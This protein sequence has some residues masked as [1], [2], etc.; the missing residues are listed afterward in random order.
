MVRSAGNDAVS[1][2]ESYPSQGERVKTLQNEVRIYICHVHTRSIHL[3][4]EHVGVRVPIA[5]YAIVI[6]RSLSRLIIIARLHFMA[7]IWSQI[8]QSADED[9]Y[10]WRKYPINCGAVLYF[11]EKIVVE[12][13]PE[14]GSFAVEHAGEEAIA[15]SK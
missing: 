5:I 4:V 2:Q 11:R 9:A 3:R 1:S 13:D 7:N 15:A 14:N 6:P 10:C 8:Y 12:S